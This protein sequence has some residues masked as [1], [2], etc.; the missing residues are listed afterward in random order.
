ME[1]KVKGLVDTLTGRL[2]LKRDGSGVHR[3]PVTCTDLA[4]ARHPGDEQL[5][6]ELVL[7]RHLGEEEVDL[8]VLAVHAV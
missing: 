5:A 2:G 6:K 4:D 8:I 1:G 3:W 7:H